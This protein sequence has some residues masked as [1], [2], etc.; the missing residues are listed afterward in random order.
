MIPNRLTRSAVNESLFG[1]GGGGGEGGPDLHL[2]GAARGQYRIEGCRIK[3][4]MG[5]PWCEWGVMCP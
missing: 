2:R 3:F 4:Q 1:G 5:G